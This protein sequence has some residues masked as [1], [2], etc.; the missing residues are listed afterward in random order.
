MI[1]VVLPTYIMQPSENEKFY[2]SQVKKIAEEIL[3][4]ECDTRVSGEKHE[5]TFGLCP[6][7][8]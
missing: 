3:K 1:E 7:R 6:Q 8:C 5:R 2:P 4:H